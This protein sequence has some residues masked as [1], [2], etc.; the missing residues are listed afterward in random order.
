MKA[1]TKVL[2][3]GKDQDE[4]PGEK[5]ELDEI[6]ET[7][8][9]FVD[10]LVGWLDETQRNGLTDLGLDSWQRDRSFKLLKKIKKD[11]YDNVERSG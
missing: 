2:K 10:E 8:E 5:E 7:C 9:E 3:H 4:E 11:F 1:Q 6:T